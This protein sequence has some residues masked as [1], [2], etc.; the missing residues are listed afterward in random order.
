MTLCW[1]NLDEQ[2]VANISDAFNNKAVWGL[3]A[4]RILTPDFSCYAS[5]DPVM[6]RWTLTERIVKRMGD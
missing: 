5:Q 2:E 4:K 1:V 6:G 3:E